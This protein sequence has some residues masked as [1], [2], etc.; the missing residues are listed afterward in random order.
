MLFAVASHCAAACEVCIYRGIVSHFHYNVKFLLKEL[1]LTY[2][3]ER[4]RRWQS[5]FMLI[6]CDRLEQGNYV[7]AKLTPSLR[8]VILKSLKEEI[9][10]P[11]FFFNI[12]Y[13]S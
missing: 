10:P 8:A 2:M 13:H 7:T 9:A 5:S 3:Y 4:P 12:L 1:S 6:H 11:D